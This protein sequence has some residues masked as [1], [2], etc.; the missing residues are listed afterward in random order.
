MPMFAEAGTTVIQR[1]RKICLLG[2]LGVGKTSLVRRFVEQRF[3]E[4]YLSTLG[5]AVNRKVIHLERPE[6]T[7]LSLLLWDIA[8]SEPFSQVVHS[9]YRGAAGALLVCD[10]TRP[11]T[12]ASLAQYAHAMRSVNPGVT[13]TLM[14]N[15]ADLAGQREIVDDQLGIAAGQLQAPWYLSSAR[16][17]EGVEPAFQALAATVV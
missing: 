16:T 12:L 9:Y 15:K 4:R 7:A 17:G 13:F 3:D 6:P 8:G 1:S 14:G 5:V 2:D 10:L 11:E